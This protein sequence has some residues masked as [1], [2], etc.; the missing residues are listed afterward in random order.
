MQN[1][2]DITLAEQLAAASDWWRDAGV[3]LVFS[4]AVVPWLAD[5]EPDEAAAP[6]ARAAAKVSATP[7]PQREPRLCA[8]ALPGTLE[9]L[10]QWWA[11][12]D[13]PFASAAARNLPPRG[14]EG[15]AL[16]V[17]APMPEAG[18]GDLLLA[19]AHGR[20]VANLASA[21]GVDGG[22]VF[23]ASALPAHQPL[24]DWA[25]LGFDGLGAALTQ[26][27][28]LARPQRVL[29]LGSKL[30]QLLGH[31]PAAPPESFSAIGQVPTLTTFAPDRLLDH[32]RQRARLWRRLLEWTSPA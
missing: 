25:D 31:D 1:R 9:A 16:M 24:P 11:S 4:D 26:L 14:A 28:A 29:L 32:P 27:V 3:D 2:T 10:R 15:A 5:P 17:I 21:L 20:L 19:G 7:T 13:N 18:D 12:A 6:A 30:P 8:A 23:L 22:E